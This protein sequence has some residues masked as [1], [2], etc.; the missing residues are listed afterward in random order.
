MYYFTDYGNDQIN[1]KNKQFFEQI[2]LYNILN[3]LEY[4]LCN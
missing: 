4:I 1:D 3:T 2:N